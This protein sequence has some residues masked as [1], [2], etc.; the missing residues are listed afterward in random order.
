M[1]IKNDIEFNYN[2]SDLVY[3]NTQ[4][5]HIIYYFTSK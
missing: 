1:Q 4:S 2:Y 5:M 3:Y